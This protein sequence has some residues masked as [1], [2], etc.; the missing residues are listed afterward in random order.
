MLC[1][2]AGSLI[3]LWKNKNEPN[4]PLQGLLRKYSGEIFLVSGMAA[5]DLLEQAGQ[6]SEA[7][8]QEAILFLGLF[9]V[10]PI[11]QDTALHYA[12]IVTHL[13]QV[14]QKEGRTRADLW[15]AATCIENGATLVTRSSHYLNTVPGLV[16]IGY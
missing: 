7:R 5:G 16:V 12:R 4:H 6:I 9:K 1:L 14:G 11:S 8:L 13:S 15:N 2:D 3:D 10:A